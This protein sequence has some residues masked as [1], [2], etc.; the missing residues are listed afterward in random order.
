KEE[1]NLTPDAFCQTSSGFIFER[2][3]ALLKT[4]N[5]SKAERYFQRV[6]LSNPS[7]DEAAYYLAVCYEHTGEKNEAISA[8]ENFAKY[9]PKHPLAESARQKLTELQK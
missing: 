9:F 3:L 5:Y 7:V 6:M 1:M 4:E 2:G 8:Y